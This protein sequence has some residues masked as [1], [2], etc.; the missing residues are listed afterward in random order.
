VRLAELSPG[1]L[2]ASHLTEF[3]QPVLERLARDSRELVQPTLTQ[4]ER[5]VWIGAA[6][7]R[8]GGW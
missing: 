8:A 1:V 6:P 5:P 3:Y 2:F 4:N 7:A